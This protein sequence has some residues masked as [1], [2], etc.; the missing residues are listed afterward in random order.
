MQFQLAS[1]VYKVILMTSLSDY[2][3]LR[4]LV[5]TQGIQRESYVKRKKLLD[6]SQFSE[7][8]KMKGKH[9]IIYESAE[10]Y[11]IHVFSS[12]ATTS[13]RGIEHTDL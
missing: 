8:E 9:Y 6:N 11:Y 13:S 3:L 12:V 7:Q 5:F 4:Y 2:L 10:V 1:E